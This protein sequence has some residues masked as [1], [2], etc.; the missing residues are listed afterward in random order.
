MK[1]V[2]TLG[3]L[4]LAFAS[5]PAAGSQY[6]VAVHSLSIAGAES[7][8]ARTSGSGS[9]AVASQTTPDAVE[10]AERVSEPEGVFGLT[11]ILLGLFGA[12]IV[13]AL[14][15]VGS[16]YARRRREGGRPRGS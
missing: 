16:R 4:L 10:P 9:L 2:F 15:W 8:P 1:L 3:L 6:P 5:A 12:A 11:R 13:G 7:M 14:M